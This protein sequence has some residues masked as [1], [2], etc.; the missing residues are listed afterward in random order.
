MKAGFLVAAGLGLGLFANSGAAVQAATVPI[1][2]NE[3]RVEV[4]ADLGALGLSATTF[5]TATADASGLYPV[6][7]FP[8]TGGSLDTDLGTALILHQGSGVTLSAGGTTATIGNFT[9]DTAASLV[10][11]DLIDETDGDLLLF[12][13]PVFDF[14]TDTSRPGVELR[15]NSVLAGLLSSTFGA[16][17]LTGAQFGF[18]TP[19]IAAVPLPAG[20]LLL[21]GGL[22]VLAGLRTRRKLAA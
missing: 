12:G 10:F 7:T 9:I 2:G 20:G 22:G 5:G 13:V 1:T 11:A 4:T 21:I 3:T 19:D 14:G 8:I 15:I 17:D 16:I 18:A 6:F